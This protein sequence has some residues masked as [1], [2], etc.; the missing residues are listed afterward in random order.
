MVVETC[1]QCEM[2]YGKVQLDVTGLE[3]VQIHPD[4][5]ENGWV[6]LKVDDKFWLLGSNRLLMD[7][8]GG[9]DIY[10]AHNLLD[11]G[12]KLALYTECPDTELAPAPV[13][14]V[15]RAAILNAWKALLLSDP[16]WLP[17]TAIAALRQR[18]A[19]MVEYIADLTAGVTRENAELV[20]VR[21]QIED[22]QT[23]LLYKFCVG[24]MPK[25]HKPT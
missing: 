4:H 8:Q 2:P 11:G 17:R 13:R 20:E 18:E 7:D 5:D 21:R 10:P 12:P 23:E 25:A 19:R 3:A 16:E 1:V 15:V 6:L 22:A 9:W 24:A 14:G